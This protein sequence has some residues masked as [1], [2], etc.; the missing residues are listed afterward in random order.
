VCVEDVSVACPAVNQL[1]KG[2]V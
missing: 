1:S 2:Y